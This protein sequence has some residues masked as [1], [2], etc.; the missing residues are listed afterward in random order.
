MAVIINV[1][2]RR[3][4]A[5]SMF[6]PEQLAAF[7]EA[8]PLLADN[9]AVLIADADT[10]GEARYAARVAQEELRTQYDTDSRTNV[11]EHEGS[12]RAALRRKHGTPRATPAPAAE[13]AQEPEQEPA[14]EPEQVHTPLPATGEPV[15]P[16]PAAPQVP[17][18]TPQA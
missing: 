2:T 7:A 4:R 1:P 18:G 17:A 5:Q 9:Q 13:P 15:T 16:V 6:T 11:F 3:R 8:L 14:Q 12:W 10:E